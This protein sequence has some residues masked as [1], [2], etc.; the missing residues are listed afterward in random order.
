MPQLDLVRFAK[1]ILDDACDADACDLDPCDVQEIAK[2]CGLIVYR[3]PT[4]AELADEEWWGHEYGIGPDN[5]GVL[6]RTPE[7]IAAC[8]AAKTETV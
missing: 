2:D 5:A 3:K 7:F 8:K 1:T 4:P 6:E